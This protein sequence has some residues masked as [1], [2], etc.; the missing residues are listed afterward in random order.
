MVPESP[1]A[2]E[3]LTPAVFHVLASL[4]DGPL[5]GYG[6]M[7]RVN[8]DSGLDMGPGTIY[9]AIHR[10]E[11]AGWVA[12]ARVEHDDPRRGKSF[13][14]TQGGRAALEREARRLTRLARLAAE[15]GLAPDLSSAS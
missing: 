4:A 15:R 1:H 10:L 3:P 2:S 8:E 7:K 6:I 13:S 14:L 9:G 11:E 12:S 5:H